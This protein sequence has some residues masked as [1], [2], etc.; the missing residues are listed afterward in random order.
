LLVDAGHDADSVDDESLGGSSD[1]RVIA[2]CLNED[3]I[4]VTLDLDFADI[5]AYP[6]S[7]HRGIWVRRPETQS[8]ENTLAALKGALALLD[9]E[10]AANRLWIIEAT[11]VRIRE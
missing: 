6:P 11:R 9:T 3:R 10:P 7:S 1:S 4:L 5:R 8:I 2:A